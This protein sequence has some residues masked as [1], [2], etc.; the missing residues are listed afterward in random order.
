MA[1]FQMDVRGRILEGI[2]LLL[3]DLRVTLAELE[4]KLGEVRESL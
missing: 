2:R 3:E 1:W 4:R